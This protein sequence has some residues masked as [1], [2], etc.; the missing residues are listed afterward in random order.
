MISKANAA[1]VIA[2]VERSP[3]RRDFVHVFLYSGLSLLRLL[4]QKN[5]RSDGARVAINAIT[6]II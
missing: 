1:P 4:S 3:I 2:N 6:I 5:S